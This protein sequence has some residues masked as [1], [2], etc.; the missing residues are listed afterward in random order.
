M[1]HSAPL[2]VVFLTNF[3]DTCFRAIPSVAQMVDDLSIHLTILHT[4]DPKRRRRSEA[5]AWLKSFFP[6]ADRYRRATRMVAPGKPVEVLKRLALSQQV[7]LVVCPGSDALGLPRLGHRPLRGS[8]A[9]DCGV[10]VWTIGRKVETVRL[11]RPVR[12]VACWMDFESSSSPHLEFAAEYASK[13]G[14]KLH[15]LHSLP[16][17]HDGAILPCLGD[18]PLHPDGVLDAVTKRLQ[19]FPIQPL[20]HV[21]GGDGRTSR[22]ALAR[23]HDA[24]VLFTSV[25]KSVWTDWIH[26]D[27]DAIDRCPCPVVSIGRNTAPAVWNLERG[28]AQVVYSAKRV[29]ASA[30]DVASAPALA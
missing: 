6:E 3:S 25:Q 30:A 7:D 24:D 29:A 4:Y 5:E 13:L 22:A 1:N 27:F 20:I 21:H 2:E 23:A 12:N 28:P 11:G 14:A 8:V 18:R 10:P 15:L 26:S 17:M 19:R 16:E 9:H